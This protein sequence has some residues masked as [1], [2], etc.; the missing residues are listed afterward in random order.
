ML[1]N[2]YLICRKY[3]IFNL[4]IARLK[5]ENKVEKQILVLNLQT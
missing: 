4:K 1:I 3:L 5:L 2:C